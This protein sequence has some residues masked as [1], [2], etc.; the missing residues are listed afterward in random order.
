MHVETASREGLQ[1]YVY[2]WVKLGKK[3][4]RM[5]TVLLEHSEDALPIAEETSGLECPLS[6]EA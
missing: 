3:V 2:C 5:P 6:L 4:Q 1:I